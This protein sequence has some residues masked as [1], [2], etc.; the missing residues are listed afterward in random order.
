MKDNLLA[1]I[2]DIDGVSPDTFQQNYNRL[3]LELQHDISQMGPNPV[4]S[5]AAS[6]VERRLRKEH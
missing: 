1:F 2:T 6:S 4:I 5:M 3:L